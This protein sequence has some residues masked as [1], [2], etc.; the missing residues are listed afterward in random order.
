MC[1]LGPL[2]L[3]FIGSGAIF[4]AASAVWADVGP[5]LTGLGVL[6]VLIGILILAQRRFRSPANHEEHT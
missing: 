1:C 3:S 2:A 5:L 4:T 6:L